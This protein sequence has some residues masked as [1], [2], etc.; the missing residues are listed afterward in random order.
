MIGA[1]DEDSIHPIG[2]ARWQAR[3][4]EETYLLRSPERR[5]DQQGHEMI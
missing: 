4:D 3:R 1:E 5:N 2:V